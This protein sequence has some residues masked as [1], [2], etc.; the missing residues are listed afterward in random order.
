MFLVAIKICVSNLRKKNFLFKKSFEFFN[1][2]FFTAKSLRAN[3][4][5][6]HDNYNCCTRLC[7]L[8]IGQLCFYCNNTMKF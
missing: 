6:I 8:L 5:N 2:A 3:L 7:N 4:T 1:T